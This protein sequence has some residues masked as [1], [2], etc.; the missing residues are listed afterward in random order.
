MP[1]Y[2]L[3]PMEAMWRKFVTSPALWA[4]IIGIFVGGGITERTIEPC[5]KSQV[6]ATCRTQ[7]REITDLA[8]KCADVVNDPAK[9]PQALRV[10]FET[11]NRSFR[12]DCVNDL[13]NE[14]CRLYSE[15]RFP[16]SK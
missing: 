7:L 13:L 10:R 16:K 9:R 11:G 8:N 14:D 6:L 15:D 5:T 1:R 2:E 4:F 12:V 3:R